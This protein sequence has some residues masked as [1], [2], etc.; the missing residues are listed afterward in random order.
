MVTDIYFFRPFRM[1]TIRII[2]EKQ[3]KYKYWQ[4]SIRELHLDNIPE[5]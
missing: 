1:D 3:G 5:N 2:P 4:G